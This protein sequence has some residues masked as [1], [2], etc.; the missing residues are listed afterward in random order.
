MRNRL[1]SKSLKVFIGHEKI[2]ET[3]PK[4]DRLQALIVIISSTLIITSPGESMRA[5][6]KVLLLRGDLKTIYSVLCSAVVTG[7][8]YLLS[9]SS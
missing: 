4:Y 9:H 2:I 8:R 1:K 6:E 5:I 7:L 3:L